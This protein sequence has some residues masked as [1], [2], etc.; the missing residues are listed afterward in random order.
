VVA[1]FGERLTVSKQA[2]QN[3]D[4]GQFNL[5][6]L[7]KMKFKKEY[8]I[9]ITIRFAALGNLIDDEDIN[10]SWENMKENIKISAKQSLG[11]HELKRHK[12]WFDEEILHFL[13]Q[14][15]QAKMHSVQD[16]I[17]NNVHNLKNLRREASDISGTKKG[18]S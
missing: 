17:Q 18:I 8:H 2:A 9:E 1:K 7:N 14:R 13:D 5:R 4:G 11:L 12:P 16:P 6:K 15:K 10:R 3:L